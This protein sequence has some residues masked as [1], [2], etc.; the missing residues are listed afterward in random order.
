MQMAP[1]L[2]PGA[3]LQDQVSQVTDKLARM[4]EFYNNAHP[5]QPVKEPVKVLITGELL[6]DEKAAASLQLPVGYTVEYLPAV[7]KYLAG[8]PIR[9]YAVN[10]GLL[11]LPRV[12]NPCRLLNL[13]DIVQ[14]RRPRTNAGAMLKKLVLPLALAAG[15]CLLT[16]SYLSRADGLADI[17]KLQAD[18]KQAQTELAQ[19]QSA[20]ARARAVQE[21]INALTSGVAAIEAGREEI[22]AS[23]RYTT[24]VSAIIAAMPEG[25]TVNSLEV[26]SGG[27]SLEGSAASAAP[28]IEYAHNL[29]TTGGFSSAVI[30]WIDKPRSIAQA[31]PQLA[32]RLQ[33]QRGVDTP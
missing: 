10:S 16:A 5:R 8:W 30:N 31:Q 21:K 27:I 19:K 7:K 14:S 22:F 18:F 11:D 3:S 23:R 12:T 4:V 25:L 13:E 24:D 26:S 28:V 32:F 2:P 9:Q 29:E 15:I 33:I 20:A 17:T 6:Q 1:A